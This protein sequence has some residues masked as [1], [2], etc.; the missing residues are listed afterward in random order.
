MATL[1]GLFQDTA[2]AIRQKGGSIDALR[3]IIFPQKILGI[4]TEAGEVPEYKKLE[5]YNRR[6]EI[7]TIV[8][9]SEKNN[10]HTI[11]CRYEK[12][13]IIEV[14]YNGKK[15]NITYS[16]SGEL[17]KVNDTEVELVDIPLEKEKILKITTEQAII[18]KS[19]LQ[20]DVTA[21]TKLSLKERKFL[22]EGELIP[23][24]TIRVIS[25]EID[26]SECN[27]DW[28]NSLGQKKSYTSNYNDEGVAKEPYSFGTQTQ[29]IIFPGGKNLRVNIKWAF[30]SYDGVKIYRGIHSDY[31]F[32]TSGEL[33]SYVSKNV[34]STG[35]D[36]FTVEEDALTFIFKS[37]GNAAKLD[38]YYATVEEFIPIGNEKKQEYFVKE[39]DSQVCCIV[40][41]K[42]DSDYYYKAGRTNILTKGE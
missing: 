31:D 40:S 41:A 34:S 30:S 17:I 14:L 6:G 19:L 25:E 13:K 36:S 7:D 10:E 26:L 20:I 16:P 2:N 11:V 38:G 9:I 23:N 21:Q 5:Y 22:I 39:T 35:N 28:C 32:N 12:E 42:E 37:T 29:V 1:G 24:T 8:L 15:I 33:K 18:I 4:P 3:P 27:F